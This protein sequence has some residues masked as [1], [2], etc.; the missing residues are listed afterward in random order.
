MGAGNILLRKTVSCCLLLLVPAALSA[1]G[2]DSAILYPGGATWVNGASVQQ[3]SALF[4]GDLVQTRRDSVASINASGSTVSVDADSLVRFDGPSLNLEHGGLAIATGREV[5]AV[6]GGVRVAPASNDWTE[7]VVS[8]VDGT[9]RIAA[10]KGNL[11][12]T[13][14]SGTVLLAQGQETTREE[15]PDASD[16]DSKKKNRRARGIGANPAAQGGW[17]NSPY[18][19]GAGTVAVGGLAAWVLLHGDNPASPSKP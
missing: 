9:V 6:A 1:A 17:L 11:N 2:P 3:S 14:G 12:V 13:D 16:K 10:R 4:V 15:T 19:V 5:A 18:A 7:F 8:D